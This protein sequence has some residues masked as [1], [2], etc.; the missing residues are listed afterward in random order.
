[1]AYRAP[2]PQRRVVPNA[3]P[4]GRPALAITGSILLI[5]GIIFSTLVAQGAI[6]LLRSGGQPGTSTTSTR[7]L[8]PYGTPPSAFRA[9]HDPQQRF[10]LF[11]SATWQASSGTINVNGQAQPATNFTP[12]GTALPSWRIAILTTT[13][14]DT[15]VAY[16]NLLNATLVAEGAQ[17]VQPRAG[18]AAVT[19]GQ[20]QW[21]RL[22]V[23]ATI[24][25]SL[26]VNVTAFI[27]Q[28]TSGSVL[29]IDE[30][31][32]LTFSTTEQQDFL[33]MVSSLTLKG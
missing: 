12:V 16:I 30:G 31:Q 32:S 19:L 13:L 27:T 22:D 4:R 17:N 8:A 18:P 33:P 14:P 15:S 5:G 11:F 29:I 25:G 10:A 24:R 9:Y 21:S 6:P 3:E 23:S 26:N 1:M 28:T 7:S 20:Y 2:S